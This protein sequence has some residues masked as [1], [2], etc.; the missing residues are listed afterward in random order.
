M[1][2][3]IGTTEEDKAIIQKGECKYI[4]LFQSIIEKSFL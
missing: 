4:Q 2:P 3:L 1:N